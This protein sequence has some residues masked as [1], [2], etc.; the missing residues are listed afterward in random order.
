MSRLEER[1]RD[2][3]WG[4]ALTV[5]PESLRRLGEAIEAQAQRPARSS[6]SR[7][8]RWPGGRVRWLAPL[9]AAAAVAVIVIVTAVTVPRGAGPSRSGATGTAAPAP[10]ATATAAPTV[11][12]PKFLIDDASGMSPLQVRNATTGALV[13][14][15]AVPPGYPGGSSRTYITGVAT[16][17]G[18][19][20]L[21]AEYANPCRSWLY[22]FRLDSEG[23]PSAVTPFAPLPTVPSELYGLTVSINGQMVGFATTACQG[24][25]AQPNYVGVTNIATGH[26]TRWTT[27]SRNSVDAVS[28]TEDGTEL[29]YSLQLASSVVRVIPTNAARGV[30]ADRG[31][32]VVRASAGR[33][34]PL[35]QI[36][37]DGGE[38]Y[39]SDYTEA[40]LGKAKPMTGQI[41]AMDLVTGQSR[42]IYTPKGGPGVMTFDQSTRYL[43]MQVFEDAQHPARLIRLNL[44]TGKVAYLPS[45]RFSLPAVLYW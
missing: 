40:T 42:L 3:Y 25:K 12:A 8:P 16:G 9:A 19:D 39:Y 28:L 27:P 43:L 21:V 45:R 18:Q 10:T 31:R 37:A 23:H 4:E 14:E 17:N 13:A 5:T 35:S 36:S 41:R 32:T 1:L 33:W 15:V 11:D 6:R 44:V 38:V 24:A 26:T 34:I 2:T 22:Q 20:Y 7:P 30:A 29:C